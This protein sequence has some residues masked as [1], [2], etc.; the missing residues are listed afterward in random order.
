MCRWFD[1]VW[2]NTGGMP[3]WPFKNKASKLAE[4]SP[5]PIAYSIGE[6]NTAEELSDTSHKEDSDYKAAMALFGGSNEEGS[7][8]AKGEWINHTD[9]YWYLKKPDGSFEPI[10]HLEDAEGNKVPFTG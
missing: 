8:D 10:P 7:K 2:H 6:E 3:I 1:D 9:G 5:A 4:E